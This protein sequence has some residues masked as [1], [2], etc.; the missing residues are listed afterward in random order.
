MKSK[1]I[2]IVGILLGIGAIVRYASLAVGG[3]ITSNLV[4]AFYALAILLISPTLLEALG[5]GIVAGIICMLISHS[6]FPPANLISEPIGAIAAVLSITGINMLI[7]D[8]KKKDNVFGL[9]LT[10]LGLLGM[11]A[12]A[13]IVSAVLLLD[14]KNAFGISILTNNQAKI[15]FGAVT[16]IL[17]LVGLFFIPETLARYKAAIVAL[18]ATLASGLAFL[19]VAAFI[20][21][22]ASSLVN[23]VYLQ[24]HHNTLPAVDGFLL[25]SL[26]IVLGC[27]I[28][29]MVIAQLL[30][31]PAKKAMR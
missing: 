6:I 21:F 11:I 20:I 25:A 1:D 12:F 30:Y 26:P 28:I 19:L 5:I 3:P 17:T 15:A 31:I 27:A 4:I 7:G 13:I 2:V 29:N 22:Q 23:A 10:V 14:P 16:I 8:T 24:E 9:V 18:L